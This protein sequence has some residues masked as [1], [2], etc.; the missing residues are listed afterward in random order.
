M[1][2]I[3]VIDDNTELLDLLRV[4]LEQRGGHQTVLSADGTDGLLQALADPPDMVISDV[5][6]P[7]MSGYEICRQLRANP[8]TASIPIIML[9]ARGQ[10]VDHQAAL[11]AG[12]DDHMV[13][14][15]DAEELLQ[16]VD[17]LLPQKE[18]IEP[19]EPPAPTRTLVLL[20][21]RG[22]VGVT[23]LAV[24]VA[25][26]LAQAGGKA[27]CLADLCSSSGHAALQLGLRPEP[28][29]SG[30]AQADIPTVDAIEAHLLQHKSS[31]R[32]LASPVFPAVGLGLSKRATL[33]TMRVL[34]QQFTTI[35]VDAPAVLN[36]AAM[37]VLE[38][39]TVVGLVVTAEPPSIQTAVGTLRALKQWS[40]KFQVILNQV[41]PGPQLPQG[42]LERA[43]K[44]P[45]VGTIP[46]DPAQARALAQG[47]PLAISNPG[48]PLAQAARTIGSQ[49]LALGN[50]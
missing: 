40:E 33:T 17:D 42:A 37:A 7:G 22:G 23:T 19:E 26:T 45:L 24:N 30:L 43:L 5:M 16:R 13:K 48:S 44:R 11:D 1:A 32:V 35:I 36:E 18:H 15:V 41:A 3:L 38:T 47:A 12:A 9:T 21:L 49:L 25:A 14:P 20:S 4:L 50:Q 2:K 27:V 29:W 39:A 28:N 6:M 31:L 34:K 46:F 8:S 10:S